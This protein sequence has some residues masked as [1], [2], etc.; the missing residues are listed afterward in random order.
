MRLTDAMGRQLRG[1]VVFSESIRYLKNQAMMLLE[2]SSVYKEEDVKWILTLPAIWSESAK[3][4]MIWCCT[5]VTIFKYTF[6]YNFK[7]SITP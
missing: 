3:Q 5:E 1:R 7:W 6:A 4:F 2:K